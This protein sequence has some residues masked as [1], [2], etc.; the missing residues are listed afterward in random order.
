[1]KKTRKLQKRVRAE[2]SRSA[3]RVADEFAVEWEAIHQMEKDVDPHHV[4]ELTDHVFR[5]VLS[6]FGWTRNEQGNFEKAGTEDA[7]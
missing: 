4:D 7:A 3:G 6:K 1:M 5:S 2:E